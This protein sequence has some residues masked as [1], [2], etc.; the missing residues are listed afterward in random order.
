MFIVHG[1]DELT[2]LDMA[3][4]IREL[5][6]V[7]I[8][9]HMQASGGRTIIEKIEE[10]TNVGFGIV[11]YT[12]CDIGAKRDSLTFKRRA[13][14]N[15]VF[16]HGYLIAKLSRSRVVAMVKGDIETPND[17]SGVIYICLDE[18]GQWK[19]K[20]VTELRSAGYAV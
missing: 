1:H 9:L 6:L 16:E 14:Q 5:D 15:V 20:L 13:R 8:I 12:P 19:D 18:E 17:I 3:N 11:L 10:Y 2:K 7:P 4:F